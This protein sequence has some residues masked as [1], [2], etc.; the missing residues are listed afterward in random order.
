MLPHDQDTAVTDV[1]RAVLS[2]AQ[3]DC[4]V[5][6]HH[7]EKSERGKRLDLRGR[8]VRIGRDP[9]N[10]MVIEGR[11]VSRQHVQLEKRDSGWV[12]LDI[13]STNGTLLND[14]EITGPSELKSG[15]RLKLGSIVVKYLSGTDVERSFHEEIYNFTI[16]DGLTQVSNRFS[17]T[18]DLAKEFS[19]AR[20]YER[21]LSLLL[22]DIDWFKRV[23]DEYGHPAGDTVLVHV[24]QQIRSNVRSGDVVAR[25]GG[26]EFAVLLLETGIGEARRIAE[27]IRGAVAESVAEVREGNIRVTLSIGCAELIPED[28]KE[29]DL[30]ERAD[31]LLY[32]A[33]GAGRNRVMG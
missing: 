18:N 14:R 5:V 8:R 27:K 10:E 1:S 24:A 3:A 22:M 29:T 19:R 21:D 7:E 30:L 16:T 13:G 20:R 31:Q 11:G 17:F 33:K 26:E 28:V 25:Y 9:D 23:N 4:I 15:D 12:A 6:I 2:P 32:A